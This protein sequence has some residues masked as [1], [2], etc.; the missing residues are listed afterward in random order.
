MSRRSISFRLTIWYLIILFSGLIVFG[1]AMWFDLK[2]SLSAG[3]SRTVGRRADR[4]IELMSQTEG[5]PLEERANKFR[6]FAN[7]TGGGLMKV[8]GANGK[9]VLPLTPAASQFPWPGFDFSKGEQLSEVRSSGEHYLVL[10]HPYL[11]GSRTLYLC[12]AAPLANNN[13][14]LARFSFGLLAAIPIVLMASALGGY[15]LS[16]KALQP[17]DRIIDSARSISILNLSERVPVSETGDELQRLTETCNDMLARLELSVNRMKQFTSDA[18]HELRTPISYTRTVAELALS[19]PRFDTRKAL[20]KIVK[21][22]AKAGHLLEDMLTLARAD[23]GQDNL[24]VE[25]V[26]LSEVVLDACEKMRPLAEARRHFFETTIGDQDAKI[27]G[28]YSS[29]RRLIWILLDNAIKYTPD[30][31]HIE[32]TLQAANDGARIT[33]KDTGIGITAADLPYIFQR[34][35]RA[36]P[37][38]SQVEGTGLGLAIAKSISDIHHARLDVFSEENIGSTLSVVFPTLS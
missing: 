15:M 28:D 36:D 22:C 13:Q 5:D 38:R 34:F 8:I 24:V 17:V 6:D 21:E 32:V 7:A 10:A 35:Y 2:H 33:V 20:E 1:A 26:N 16:R 14:L 23:T 11:S 12:V 29:L 4:L 31:G 9:P 27:L 18:S 37:S 3:R 19:N 30:G 25:P